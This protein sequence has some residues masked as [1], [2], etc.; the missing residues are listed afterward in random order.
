MKIL[1]PTDFSPRSHVA[2]RF[3]L[4]LAQQTAGAVELLHVV[5]PRSEPGALAIDVA[6]LEDRIRKNAETS[7]QAECRALSSD[8]VPAHGRGAAYRAL[9]GSVSAEVVRLAH[10]PVLVVTIPKET[11]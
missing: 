11:S 9:V 5:S 7:L 8:T 2:A 10:R 3:A 4:A 1:C 6:L